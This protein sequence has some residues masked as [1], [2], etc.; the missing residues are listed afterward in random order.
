MRSSGV[1][2][3]RQSDRA[4]RL[5]LAANV[6]FSRYDGVGQ[7]NSE[8]LRTIH[9]SGPCHHALNLVG[10]LEPDQL[11]AAEHVVHVRLHLAES[12]AHLMRV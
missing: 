9:Q 3:L 5:C 11:A 2:H 7:K 1:R 12:E 8:A 4:R 6:K 10:P